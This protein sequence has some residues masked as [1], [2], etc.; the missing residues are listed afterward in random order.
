MDLYNDRRPSA[1]REGDDDQPLDRGSLKDANS[2]IR[3]A[4]PAYR[5]GDVDRKIRATAVQR[6]RGRKA[7]QD[8]F[9]TVGAYI[10]FVVGTDDGSE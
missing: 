6:H 1:R 8:D 9:S 4:T 10:N 2:R 3:S 7:G 5:S